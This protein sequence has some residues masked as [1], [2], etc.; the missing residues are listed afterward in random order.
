MIKTIN[1]AVDGQG[2]IKLSVIQE[3]VKKQLLNDNLAKGPI[4]GHPDN[5]LLLH[6]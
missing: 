1:S 3:H 4:F 5:L 6:L 2:L